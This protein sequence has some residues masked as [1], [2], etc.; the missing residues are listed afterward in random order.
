MSGRKKKL[1]KGA[2]ARAEQRQKE[3][4]DK[5]FAELAMVCNVTAALEAARMSGKSGQ[6]YERRRR[7]PEYRARWEE[8]IVESY[9][10]L[11]LEMLERSRRGDDRPPPKTDAERRLRELTDRQ[12]MQLLRQHKSGV[13]GAQPHAQRPFRGEKL[14]GAVE[15]RLG[16]I[17][18]RLGGIG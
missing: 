4:D 6:V 14:L 17:S 18:R 3:K 11:E 5:F 10:M 12:A 8:A 13:K 9:A 16:E 15:K 1:S 2:L 7:D